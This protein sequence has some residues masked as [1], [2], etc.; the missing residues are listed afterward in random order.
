MDSSLDLLVLPHINVP[1]HGRT[2]HGQRQDSRSSNE[3]HLL[4]VA[5]RLLNGDALRGSHRVRQLDVEAAVDVREVADGGLGQVDGQLL[6]EDGL[7]DGGGDGQADGAADGRGH[8]FDGEDDGDVLVGGGGH[9][10]GLLADDDDVG[11]IAGLG[12]IKAVDHL[13]EAEEVAVPDVE[14]DEDGRGEDVGADDGAV[15]EERVW[16]EGD[17]REPPL[18]DAKDD[19]S[20]ESSD[21]EAEDERRLPAFLLVGVDVEGEEEHGQSS[22]QD[23]QADEVK[24]AS[25]VVQGVQRG[26]LSLAARDDAELLRLLVVVHEEEEQGGGDDGGDDGEGAEAPAETGAVEEGVGD[27]AGDPRGDDGGPFTYT[28]GG[29]IPITQRGCV[30]EEDGER[31]V[32]AIVSDPVKDLSSGVRLDVFASSHHD[33]AQSGEDD[34]KQVTL[35]TAKDVQNF[36]KRQLKDTTNDAAHDADGRRQG[37]L[38]EGGGDPG[39]EV[40]RGALL[41]AVDEVDDP[42][43]GKGREEG[44]LCPDGGDGLD[45]LDTGLGAGVD[46]LV[47]IRVLRAA[48]LDV[49]VFLAGFFTSGGDVVALG[50]VGDGHCLLGGGT[51]KGCCQFES[52]LVLWDEGGV[53]TWVSVR[54]GQWMSFLLTGS[55]WTA[56]SDTP[57]TVGDA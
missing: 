32:Q 18:P 40:A 17:G 23:E 37:V 16:D 13:E 15:H 51:E 54:R 14:A 28:I 10:G 39:R 11:N 21:Q 27:G 4:C 42:D 35:R 36:G 50:E 19:E 47:G 3:H 24:L 34:G 56:A 38:L 6:G 33:Q 48:D 31:V 44:A 2:N 26:A 7:P 41:H 20:D 46:G 8:C 22:R 30:C 9:D 29:D 53:E 43:H 55:V 49:W 1:P 45:V 12:D 5:I 57:A 25:V 52:F